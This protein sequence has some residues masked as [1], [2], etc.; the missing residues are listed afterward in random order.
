MALSSENQ[1]FISESKIGPYPPPGGQFSFCSLFGC[2]DS[3][4]SIVY[5]KTSRCQNVENPG[6]TLNNPKKFDRHL[7]V[8]AY[9]CKK[10][11]NLL[12]CQPRASGGQLAAFILEQVFQP[13]NTP[14]RELSAVWLMR[15]TKRLITVPEP[16]PCLLRNRRWPPC[17]SIEL[18]LPSRLPS[19]SSLPRAGVIFTPQLFTVPFAVG[20]SPWKL[21][22]RF[23]L[24]T[25]CQMPLSKR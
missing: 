3:I 24:A 12:T 14:I 17:C 16:S 6:K 13:P 5:V 4:I 10:S 21:P 23:W 15:G 2:I 7:A 11:A 25:T 1:A 19:S 18:P 20:R 9:L 22:A 8:H